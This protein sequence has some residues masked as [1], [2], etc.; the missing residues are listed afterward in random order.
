MGD[1]FMQNNTNA[2]SECARGIG[3][4]LDQIDTTS[5]SC[6]KGFDIGAFG[7]GSV[8]PDDVN[9]AFVMIVLFCLGKK[10]D[11]SNSIN[12]FGRG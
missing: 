1:V 2:Q 8:V 9:N 4:P 7:L 11:G 5:W 3:L 10:R 6:E 12:S